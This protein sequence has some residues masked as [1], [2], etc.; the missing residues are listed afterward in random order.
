MALQGLINGEDILPIGIHVLEP[1]RGEMGQIF[2]HHRRSLRLD[3][4]SANLLYGFAQFM[5]LRH[6]W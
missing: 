4:V 2:F 5:A 6:F 3:G 1:C